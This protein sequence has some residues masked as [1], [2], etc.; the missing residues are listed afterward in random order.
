MHAV[1]AS[2]AVPLIWPAVTIGGRQ[3]VDGGMR[4]PTNADVARDCDVIVVLAPLPSGYSR[5]M[6]LRAQL[7]RTGARDKIVISPDKLAV[8][9]FGSNVLDHSK[10]T[11][12]AEAGLRQAAE[13]VER[14]RETLG[15][16]IEQ[17][18]SR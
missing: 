4:S 3:Y 12:A 11:V 16:V 7:G 15:T 18:A 10:R 8:E 5:T 14:L 6:S 17:R 2:C 13:T 9:T 1:A